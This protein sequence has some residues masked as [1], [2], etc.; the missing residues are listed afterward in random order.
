M[1]ISYPRN[2]QPWDTTSGLSEANGDVMMHFDGK[3]LTSPAGSVIDIYDLTGRIIKTVW[4]AEEDLSGLPRG[5]FI[6][7]PRNTDMQAIKFIML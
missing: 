1:D 2:L 4:S 6:A 3:T 7:C 5:T